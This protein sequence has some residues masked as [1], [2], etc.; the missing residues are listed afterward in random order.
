MFCVVPLVYPPVTTDIILRAIGKRA[1]AL[2]SLAFFSFECVLV[3]TIGC[4]PHLDLL[5]SFLMVHFGTHPSMIVFNIPPVIPTRGSWLLL[6]F[7]IGIFGMIGQV[8]P[9]TPSSRLTYPNP[10]KTLL[11]MGFQRET[12]S[13]GTLAIYTSVCLLRF[14]LFS[15]ESLTTVSGRLCCYTRVHRFPYD[16]HP[17]IDRRGDHYHKL[18]YLY[19]STYP[20]SFRLD[21]TRAHGPDS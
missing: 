10:R 9:S 14:G 4:A 16:A 11:A 19:L 17:A 5:R 7:L 15:R 20:P 6:M 18:G 2:H 12:A 1:H 13:R 8:C 3:S 21:V